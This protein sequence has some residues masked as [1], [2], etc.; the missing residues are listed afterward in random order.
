LFSHKDWHASYHKVSYESIF[1]EYMNYAL[2]NFSPSVAER[3]A[4]RKADL[5]PREI[6]KAGEDYYK[7]LHTDKQASSLGHAVITSIFHSIVP[8]LATQRV[9]VIRTLPT[10]TRTWTNIPS[11]Y[12][13]NRAL[14]S[15]VHNFLVR[16]KDVDR[17]DNDTLLKE[18][19]TPNHW[20]DDPRY[21]SFFY[22]NIEWLMRRLGVE[23]GAILSLTEGATRI[24]N[25][26]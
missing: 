24:F 13:S 20:V 17:D 14:Y 9:G 25:K 2:F 3:K 12:F 15:I 7:Y 21:K 16:Y 11:E 8:S 18:M 10:T 1:Q 4:K 5:I 26:Y 6:Y 23:E 22:S 19:A